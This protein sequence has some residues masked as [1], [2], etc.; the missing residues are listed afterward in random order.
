VASVVRGTLLVCA[1]MGVYLACLPGTVVAGRI[2]ELK[3]APPARPTLT[4][5]SLRS[6]FS[7]DRLSGRGELTFSVHYGGGRPNA[8]FPGGPRVPSALRRLVLHLPAG[9]G[10]DIPELRTCSVARL[11]AHGAHG[12][13]AASRIGRGFALTKL[14]AGSQV[15][16]ERITISAY[17]GPE[18]GGQPTLALLARGFTPLAERLVFKGEMR[19]DHAPY[20]EELVLN[21]P[22][23]HALPETPDA[24]PVV[25]SLTLGVRSRGRAARGNTVIVPSR[26]PAGGFP[27]AADSTYADGSSGRA[28]TT[29]LCP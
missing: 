27:F 12:C 8:F 23:I 3:P 2:P 19:F 10:L 26:C 29:A 28:V 25:F 21:V 14:A 15:L 9:A 5:A 16:S 22:R 11:R 13:P 24:S 6:S 20:G 7:P 1:L 4:T 17:V 18:R